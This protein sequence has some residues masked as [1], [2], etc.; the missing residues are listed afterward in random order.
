MTDSVGFPEDL[1]PIYVMASSILF[2]LVIEA[3]LVRDKRAWSI[4]ALGVY[5]TIGAW[6]FVE[7]FY[8]PEN[9]LQFDSLILEKC[10]WQIIIF[11]ISFRLFIPSL[12]R[13]FIN[14][15]HTVFKF[16]TFN[17]EQLLIVL[18]FVWLV[19]LAY[20]VSRVNGNIAA[21]LFPVLGRRGIQMWGR[22]ATGGGGGFIVSSAGYVYTLVCA[23]FGVLLPL[24]MSK[25]FKF[26]NILLIVIVLPYFIF[27][28]TRNLLLAVIMPGYFSYA[29]FSRDSLWKKALISMATFWAIN[30]LMTL[31]IT[32][33]NIG[34]IGL[35]NPDFAPQFQEE[36]E[37]EGHLGL[38]MLE[39]L[40]YI[41]QFYQEGSINLTYGGRYLAEA[42][43]I[44]PRA[45]WPNKPLIGIDYAILR[46]FGG[47]DNDIGVFATISTGLIGQGFFNFGPIFGPMGAAILM[48][49]W[50][51]FMSRLWKQQYS[52]L[53]LGLFLI[54]L[55]LTFNLGR[56]FTLLVLWPAL[57]GYV[58]VLMLERY[59][60]KKAKGRFM[61]T[62]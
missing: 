19:L 46:G 29:L 32:Y 11:L 1:V 41:N 61:S 2:I 36:V 55:G 13:R 40:C 16:T 20:G 5:A 39:E 33:R 38:N 56:E 14:K 48:A 18:A 27:L 44:I 3:F 17:P 7:L 25:I 8:T 42:A 62:S 49:S 31:I 59:G 34:F 57:F 23:F 26:L 28:G 58:F 22:S 52:T 37:E 35:F 45:I 53:R 9:F 21:A 54:C 30:E 10:Y 47:A 12:S 15:Y 60:S 51:S 4:P 6:Y 43:N 50:V 24:P